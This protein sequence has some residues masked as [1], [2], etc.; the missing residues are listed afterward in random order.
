LGIS[1]F[2]LLAWYD[3]CP[4]REIFW[5]PRCKFFSGSRETFFLQEDI[6]DSGIS[7]GRSLFTPCQIFGKNARKPA[8]SAVSHFFW[9]T[10]I[11]EGYPLDGFLPEDRFRTRPWIPFSA[12][13]FLTWLPAALHSFLCTL[14]QV[15]VHPSMTWHQVCGPQMDHFITAWLRL[16]YPGRPQESLT[17]LR[18]NQVKGCTGALHDHAL[19]TSQ[20]T[21]TGGLAPGFHYIFNRKRWILKRTEKRRKVLVLKIM[22]EMNN[23][24]N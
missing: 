2:F 10:V 22:N 9:H 5:L 18:Y 24:K 6:F 12:A 14:A 19:A 16:D 17:A 7:G 11:I 23:L 21:P 13:I 20:A 15:A 8:L 4:P 1:A 3:S